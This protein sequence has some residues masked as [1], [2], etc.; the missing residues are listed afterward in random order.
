MAAGACFGATG[1]GRF[2][3]RMMAT[4]D[5]TSVAMLMMRSILIFMAES[6]IPHRT[7]E[8]SLNGT[9]REPPGIR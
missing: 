8:T 6:P 1:A 7:E 5:A 3:T 9:G 2:S 4:N